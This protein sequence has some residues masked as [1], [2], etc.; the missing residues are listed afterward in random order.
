[1]WMQYL[2][3]GVIAIV[4]AI[5]SDGCDLKVGSQ[6]SGDASFAITDAPA[7]DVDRVRLTVTAIHLGY[8]RGTERLTLDPPVVVNNLLELQGS[9]SQILFPLDE[10]RAGD[11]EWLRLFIS[12]QDGDSEV[13]TRDTGGTLPLRLGTDAP[14]TSDRY[15][16][17]TRDFRIEPNESNRLTIDL[18][19]R[20]ALLKPSG[21]DFYLLRPAMR[22]VNNDKS[23][24][25]EGTVSNGLINTSSCTSDLA[26]DEGRGLGNAVYLY[27]G[28]NRTPG[29]I[30]VNAQGQPVGTRLNPITTAD[31]RMNLTNSTYEFEIGF[32]PQGTY[33]VA[34]TCR[35]LGD[36]PNAQDTNVTF[37]KVANVTV[38][39]GETRTI[40]LSN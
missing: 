37:L 31:V 7:D 40:N 39:A 16:Q 1:M 17:L 12:E 18:D 13:R 35:S 8:D 11:Y 20:R 9:Q 6:G 10:I 21:E 28:S 19:L 27:E 36:R 32:V 5:A 24:I 2:P 26:A 22:L 33:T 38:A 14:G 30:H 15:L 4:G 29:D 25:I 3:F 34:F 23:G